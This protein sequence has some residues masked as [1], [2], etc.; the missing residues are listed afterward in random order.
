M[1]KASEDHVTVEHNFSAEEIRI[2]SS[3]SSVGPR[4]PKALNLQYWPSAIL[5]KAAQPISEVT[6]EVRVLAKDMIFTM[7]VYHGIGL[8]A[9]QVGRSIRMFVAD[10]DWVRGTKYANPHVFINPTVTSIGVIGAKNPEGCLSFPNT[11]TD[12]VRSSGVHIS[13]TDMD[14]KPFELEAFGL[15]ARVIQHENDH[16]NGVTINE[17]LSRTQRNDLRKGLKIVSRAR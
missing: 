6:N 14:G 17:H 10:V 3:R 5:S 9:P 13:A 8:A 4:K 1:H 7:M 15:M 11:S 2:M 16:L 12:V